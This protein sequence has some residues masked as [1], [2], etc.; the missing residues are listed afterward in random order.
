MGGVKQKNTGQKSEDCGNRSDPSPIDIPIPILIDAQNP[1]RTRNPIPPT[2]ILIYCAS[3]PTY[4]FW[5]QL[6]FSLTISD[7]VSETESG[8]RMARLM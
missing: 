1:I 2:D 5:P 7:N 8:Q 4:T 3:A 6:T